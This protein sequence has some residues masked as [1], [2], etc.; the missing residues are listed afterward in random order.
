MEPEH[1]PVINPDGGHYPHPHHPHHHPPYR[2]EPERPMNPILVVLGV[3]LAVLLIGYTYYSFSP[4][5]KTAA[6]PQQESQPQA[7]VQ[8]PAQVQA[9][10]PSLNPTEPSSSPAPTTAPAGSAALLVQDYQNWVKTPLES[11]SSDTAAVLNS[12]NTFLNKYRK[13]QP[14]PLLV[15][16]ALKLRDQYALQ[17]LAPSFA[18]LKQDVVD[19]LLHDEYAKASAMV[20]VWDIKGGPAFHAAVTE[21]LEKIQKLEKQEAKAAMDRITSMVAL[22]NW[23]EAGHAAD[24]TITHMVSRFNAE[25]VARAM[26]LREFIRDS[27]L[28][29]DLVSKKADERVETQET[30]VRESREKALYEKLAVELRGLLANLDIASAQALLESYK[31]QLIHSSKSADVAALA[32]DVA[33]MEVLRRRITELATQGQLKD[34]HVSFLGGSYLIAGATLEGPVLQVQQSSA[35]LRWAELTADDLKSIV[36]HSIDPTLGTDNLQWGTYLY[37]TGEPVAA[38]AALVKASGMG[39]TS[40]PLLA[41]VQ[42]MRKQQLTVKP[43]PK[44]ALATV[45]GWDSPENTS[46]QLRAQPPEIIQALNEGGW[47]ISKGFWTITARSTFYAEWEDPTYPLLTLKRELKRF[48]SVSA[49]MRAIG[50]SVGFSFGKDLRFMTKPT[51]RWQ[52]LEI[53]VGAG[54]AIKFFVDGKPAQ[55]LENE[56]SEVTSEKLPDSIFL[57]CVGRRFEVRNYQ[58]DNLPV[59]SVDLPWQMLKSV[60]TTVDQTAEHAGVLND[61]GWKIV[62]GRWSV[63][64]NRGYLAVP[65]SGIAALQRN[66]PRTFRRMSV[67]FRGAGDVAGF[68]FGTNN[69]YLAKPTEKWQTLTLDVGQADRLQMTVDTENRKSLHAVQDIPIGA[70]PPRMNLMAHGGAVE[71]RNFS[72]NGVALDMPPK[73]DEEDA[74]LPAQQSP[75]EAKQIQALGLELSS[76]VWKLENDG[77]LT[78]ARA[79]GNDLVALKYRLSGFREISVELRG[80]GDLAGF[81]FG[82]GKRW[83][84]RA[85]DTWQKL[86][87]RILDDGKMQ[88]LV[89]GETRGS[90]ED[91]RGIEINQLGNALYLRGLC[92]NVQFRHFKV[93]TE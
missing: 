69:R 49:E 83:S 84:V 88:F 2:P 66:T 18:A 58:V 57:R 63:S 85:L 26:K 77:T 74:M 30:A 9:Q 8:A 11:K 32:N 22:G 10:L 48:K 17:A 87:L 27:T 35:G 73:V 91:T 39:I 36:Q 52:K 21:E 46:T 51:E 23:Q 93:I 62:E 13:Q 12:I 25:Y 90:I 33:Q 15:Q 31:P 61:R 71:F 28:A 89:N 82:Q 6:A 53:K 45:A 14:E 4:V 65:L 76:G 92:V 54:D 75:E 34:L 59:G 44:N 79:E 1:R 29:E 3:V 50:G 41:R 86:Q 37:Q 70:L 72:L 40:A 55:S 42:E 81:S 24:E 38:E 43:I 16:Q 5:S 64:P 7:Q 78:G 68:D 80:E 67:E 60:Y 19:L 20:R 47:S 56:K